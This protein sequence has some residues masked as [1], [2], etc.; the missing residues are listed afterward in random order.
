VLQKAVHLFKYQGKPA[1]GKVLGKW[2]AAFGAHLLDDCTY[3]FLMPVP[4]HPQR[5]RE[6]GYNQALHLCTWVHSIHEIP[7]DYLSLRRIRHTIPQV[8]LDRQARKR[9]IK[10]AFALKAP[11][12]VEDLSVLLV[13]DVYTSGA[14]VN[15][16]AKVLTRA[17]ARCVDVLTLARA[18]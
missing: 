18:L 12:T 11:K 4:L 13:D 15:E 16:C 6:R 3:D 7:I 2:M 10:G 17:G 5:L 8:G 14:T 9:N 1:L